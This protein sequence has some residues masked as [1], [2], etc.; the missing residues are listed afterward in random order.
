[1]FIFNNALENGAEEVMLMRNRDIV[2]TLIALH[3]LEQSKL[4]PV[5]S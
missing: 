4:P 2:N 3:Q 1:M 5:Q